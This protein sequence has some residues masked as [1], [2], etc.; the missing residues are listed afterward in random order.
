[1]FV[2]G[3]AAV[4]ALYRKVYKAKQRETG[5]GDLNLEH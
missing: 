1:M 4:S 2:S 5:F 3:L